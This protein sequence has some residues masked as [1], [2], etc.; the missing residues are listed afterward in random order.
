MLCEMLNEIIASGVMPDLAKLG[1]IWKIPKSDGGERPITLL[2][3]MVYKMATGI[4]STRIFTVMHDQRACSNGSGRF[5]GVLAPLQ[6][7]FREGMNGMNAF[8]LCKASVESMWE[9]FQAWLHNDGADGT[10]DPT[11]HDNY[12]L[13]L[14]MRKYFDYCTHEIIEISCRCLKFPERL[15]SLILEMG[16]QASTMMITVYGLSDPEELK[17][18]VRQG[19]SLSVL[20]AI[21]II[22][23]ILRFSEMHPYLFAR[24]AQGQEPP[25]LSGVSFADDTTL[26]SGGDGKGR[27][28]LDANC[29]FCGARSRL[30]RLAFNGEK[31]T[32]WAYFADRPPV[33]R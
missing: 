23:V 6:F 12:I 24:L 9:R 29:D 1:A 11:A 7:A 25:T 2:N 26:M 17:G 28:S 13:Y 10:D 19:C 21:V 27:L 33:S 16:R 14:D 5:V 22:S 31:S 20:T 18:S 30:A 8:G 32:L 3:E 4:V 15:I